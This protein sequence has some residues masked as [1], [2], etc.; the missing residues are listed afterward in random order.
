MLETTPK[1]ADLTWHTYSKSKDTEKWT[2]F[3]ARD[4][5]TQNTEDCIKKN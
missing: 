2:F 3:P 5:I 4:A 1:P